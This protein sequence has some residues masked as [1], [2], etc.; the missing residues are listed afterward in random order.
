MWEGC[1]KSIC[2]VS[3]G[4]GEI[5]RN[6]VGW[7]KKRPGREFGR[8]GDLRAG[9]CQSEEDS[10]GVILRKSS[11]PKTQATQGPKA[12]AKGRV[13]QWREKGMRMSV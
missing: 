4:E 6:Y 1:R 10:H 12:G 13:G 2:T 9:C 7:G 5:Q 8:M 11:W 3:F